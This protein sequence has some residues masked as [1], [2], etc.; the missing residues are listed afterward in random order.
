MGAQGSTGLSEGG[1][2]LVG[3]L[4]GVSSGLTTPELLH[5]GRPYTA[6][7][8]AVSL[9]EGFAG[10]SSWLVSEYWPISGKFAGMVPRSIQASFDK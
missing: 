2:D 7:W 3:Q 6:Q 10:K 1:S 8:A 4:H 9:L 5:F